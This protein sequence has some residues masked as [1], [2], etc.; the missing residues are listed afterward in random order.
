[1]FINRH[2]CI[3]V[4]IVCWCASNIENVASNPNPFPLHIYRPGKTD[5]TRSKYSN[6]PKPQPLPEFA[7]APRQGAAIE[8][9]LKRKNSAPP[10]SRQEKRK[11]KRETVAWM[12]I[13]SPSTLS[14]PFF[15][16]LHLPF[17]HSF[18]FSLPLP[19]PVPLLWCR[20]VRATRSPPN[21]QSVG[22]EPRTARTDTTH[23]RVDIGHRQRAP[24]ARTGGTC[25]T[26]CRDNP[27]NKL[28]TQRTTPT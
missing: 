26:L 19:L 27:T 1:M 25:E 18:S 22:F 9:K 15:L 10:Y 4:N 24:S 3:K 16:P 11:K 17:R 20:D 7:K 5:I 28:K 21:H 12:V 13:L 2:A 6:G 14:L 23:L 8:K